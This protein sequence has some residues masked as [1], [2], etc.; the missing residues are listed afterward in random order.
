MTERSGRGHRASASLREG[1]VV[2]RSDPVHV[3]RA[4]RLLP[5]PA[6]DVA[7][8]AL[9]GFGMATSPWRQL[10]GFLLV[11]AKRCGSTSLFDYL[12]QH[13][14]VANLFP[15]AE[16]RKGPHYF[17]HHPGRPPAW[18]RSHFA[19]R[20][21]GRVTGD[22]STYYLAHPRAASRA[23]ALLPAAKV[24]VLL[25]EPAERAFSQYRDEVRLG[26]ETLPF[27]QALAAEDARTAPELARMAT[28]PGYSGFAH[29]HLAYRGWGHYAEHL[30]RWVTL[31]GADRVLALGTEDLADDPQ[32]VVRRCTEFLGLRP[33]RPEVRRLN[34][35]PP[36]LADPEVMQA[37]RDHYRPHN[38]RLARLLPAAPSW[39]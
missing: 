21:P 8:H 37:L 25:R 19:F 17:D 7:R 31:F 36:G 38:A 2:F 11:G 5:R 34:A 6:K 15:A 22:A 35:A 18:Y 32:G 12:L 16:G 9:R 4:K 33:F 27:E 39:P 20:R 30:E 26:H 24:V 29:E 14:D 3:A 10:P 28:D 13:P 1:T 23:A